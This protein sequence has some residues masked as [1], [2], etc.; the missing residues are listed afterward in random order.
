MLDLTGKFQF[1]RNVFIIIGIISLISC[2]KSKP[3]SE[4]EQISQSE[5]V[6]SDI[7]GSS[8]TGSDSSDKP[9]ESP[10]TNGEPMEDPDAKDEPM[11]DPSGVPLLGQ[12]EGDCDNSQ[13][14]SENFVCLNPNGLKEEKDSNEH[15]FTFMIENDIE[16]PGN[17]TCELPNQNP[18]EDEDDDDIKL[19]PNT[20][21]VKSNNKW[22]FVYCSG[23]EVRVSRN[24]GNK[25]SWVKFGDRNIRLEGGNR[26]HCP[27][28][29]NGMAPVE[30]KCNGNNENYH[31]K[32]KSNAAHFVPDTS[33][34]ARITQNEEIYIG[35]NNNM[36]S[37]LKV[38][39]NKAN[40][41]LFIHSPCAL[42]PWK[43]KQKCSN[44]EGAYDILLNNFEDPSGSGK[45]VHQM[46][47]D[48]FRLNN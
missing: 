2:S 6:S 25:Q 46:D 4:Y 20:L 30:C 23:S 40:G 24:L 44:D 17:E 16:Q 11:E 3:K 9:E 28:V 26:L 14:C 27:E 39:K 31:E 33:A 19:A 7:P 12:G 43:T 36:N 18:P 41:E 38:V 37:C 8:T 1:F 21:V 32:R 15:G 42:E 10:D 34:P 29:D 13:E 35:P 48:E 45:N 47:C 5:N 22:Y